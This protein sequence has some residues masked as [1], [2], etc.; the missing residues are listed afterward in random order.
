MTEKIIQRCNICDRVNSLEL[1]THY[2]QFTSRDFVQDPHSRFGMICMDC[3]ESI[4]D[5]SAEI[6]NELEFINEEDILSF[7]E[8]K[9]PE[10]V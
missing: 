10:D 6:E 9:G 7:F 2:E 1:T 3:N 8:K 5:A 4:G